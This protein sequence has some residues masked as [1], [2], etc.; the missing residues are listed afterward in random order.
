M[1]DV[2]NEV[3]HRPKYDTHGFVLVCRTVNVRR[4]AAAGV[5]G[6]SLWLW[7]WR[8]GVRISLSRRR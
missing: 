6:L 3:P 8:S 4:Q 2:T 5:G 1:G 7:L